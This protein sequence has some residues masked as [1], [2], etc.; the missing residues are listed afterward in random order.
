MKLIIERFGKDQVKASSHFGAFI[1]KMSADFNKDISTAL[2][3]TA[4][5]DF[6]ETLR[7]NDFSLEENATY[8]ICNQKS[9]ISFIGQVISYEDEYDDD[10]GVVCLQFDIDIFQITVY[11][12]RRFHTLLDKYVKFTIKKVVLYEYRG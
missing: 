7:Y 10:E 8:A 12:D 11:K 9:S 1:A 4:E 2:H 5:L 3:I 6:P